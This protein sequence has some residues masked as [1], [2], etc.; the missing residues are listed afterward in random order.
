MLNHTR[1][2]RPSCIRHSR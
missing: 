1:L 2:V